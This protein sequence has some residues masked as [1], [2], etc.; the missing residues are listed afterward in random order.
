MASHGIPI[1]V[2]RDKLPIEYVE[3]GNEYEWVRASLLSST[4]N[5]S[6]IVLRGNTTKGSSN[7][8][9]IT[10]INDKEASILRANDESFELEEDL[11]NLTHLVRSSLSNIFIY[12]Y[13][14]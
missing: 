10:T 14:A 2:K 1:Y 11:I 4:A 7:V 9:D 13:F 12:V 5:G 3:V 6:T 8:I